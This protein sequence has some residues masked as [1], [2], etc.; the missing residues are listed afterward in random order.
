MHARRVAP[1]SVV[2]SQCVVRGAEVGG[3]NCNR[4]G[5]A[6]F[7]VVAASKLVARSAAQATVEQSGAQSGRLGPVALAVQVAIP[8]CSTCNG[9]KY[10]SF[11]DFFMSYLM[12][13]RLCDI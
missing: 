13:Q 5:N 12:R 8:T 2:T 11:M 4:A 10:T 6:P 9:E 1:P 7:R 3:S